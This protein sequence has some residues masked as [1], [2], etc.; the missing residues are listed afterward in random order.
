MKRSV[1]AMLMSALLI[2]CLVLPV[3]A[4][5]VVR[6]GIEV[7]LT[8]DKESYSDLEVINAKLTIR[9]TNDYPI[10]NVRTEITVPEGYKLLD[11][12]TMKIG[13]LAA[14]AEQVLQTNM[15]NLEADIPDL[16][17]T[18]DDSHGGLWLL[19]MMLSGI[20]LGMRRTMAFCILD[21]VGV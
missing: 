21:E 3:G 8:T 15:R 11:S 5:T 20:L 18:G 19:L 13:T 4:E 12:G 9:N 1:L 17:Q 6:D 14:G 7:T 2:C 16:P 10:Q